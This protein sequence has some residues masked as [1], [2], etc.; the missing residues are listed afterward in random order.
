MFSW[1]RSRKLW[2]KQR[3]IYQKAADFFHK[4]RGKLGSEE[5]ATATVLREWNSYILEK[6]DLASAMEC[7]KRMAEKMPRSLEDPPLWKQ[8]THFALSIALAI[9]LM[10][11]LRPTW[12]EHQRVPSGSM[13]STLLEKQ[14]VIVSKTSYGINSPFSRS[15]IFRPEG[16]LRR[17]DIVT[18]TAEGIRGLD[19]KTNLFYLFPSYKRLV[20][21]LMALGGD[22]VYFYGGKVWTL[23][24]TSGELKS[25]FDFYDGIKGQEYIPFQ[26]PSG[27]SLRGVYGEKNAPIYATSLF[28]YLLEAVTKDENNENTFLEPTSGKPL[29]A[30]AFH[31]FG[32]GNY[33]NCRLLTKRQ[34]FYSAAP[35]LHLQDEPYL[36]EISHH[37][38]L[39]SSSTAT[40]DSA[41][42]LFLQR[43]ILPLTEEAVTRLK[44]ALSTSRFELKNG[45]LF[46]FEI[47]P[48]SVDHGFD[49][50]VTD[51]SQK[52][53]NGTYELE[54]GDLYKVGIGGQREKLSSH[55]LLNDK[56]LPL[57]FNC[58]LDWN[59]NSKASANYSPQLIKRFAYFNEGDLYCM[60]HLIY[61]KDDPVLIR[62]VQSEQMRQKADP[63]YFPFV[64][65]GVPT[66]E[67]VEEKGL[68]IP[69]DQ[70]LVLGD[71][72]AL[73]GDS[74]FFGPIPQSNIEGRP[75]AII[76]PPSSFALSLK[77]NPLTWAQMLPTALYYL[78]FLLIIL[79]VWG[80]NRRYAKKI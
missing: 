42:P 57:L 36:L 76:W 65:E 8:A 12:L 13:R 66:K 61:A 15:K 40:A 3:A 11:L 78:T 38:S 69:K 37:G 53:L 33:G 2:K 26:H 50:I 62:F 44:Q 60:G 14:H 51:L 22:N 17:G 27:L 19:T 54:K 5:E 64:D 47:D 67:R 73:S 23:D 30:P 63:S 31:M 46:R 16:S 20:K 21:R 48:K 59:K 77:Q 74:R 56:H 24:S 58:G 72:H 4:N 25:N 68:T 35:T 32:I 49:I 10:L 1:L 45:R 52:N 75:V 29:T 70:L 9:A 6:Q 79:G 39:L 18:F 34:Y 41:E 43:S 71:N 7:Q 80:Y 55:P 28:G